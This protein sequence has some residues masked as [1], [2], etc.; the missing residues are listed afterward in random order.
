MDERGSTLLCPTNTVKLVNTLRDDRIYDRTMIL[1]AVGV[2]GWP[3]PSTRWDWWPMLGIALA[4]VIARRSLRLPLRPLVL[5]V[6]VAIGP[7]FALVVHAWGAVAAISSTIATA[8]FSSWVRT[9]RTGDGPPS[10]V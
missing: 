3:A 5:V 9:R 7:I 10:S 2:P 4:L 1:F 6:A 8:G